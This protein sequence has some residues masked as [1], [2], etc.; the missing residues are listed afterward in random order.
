[1]ALTNRRERFWDQEARRRGVRTGALITQGYPRINNHVNALEAE[2]RRAGVAV[3]DEQR[4]D[5]SVR[6]F[7][8][9]IGGRSAG[10]QTS[11][12][13]KP[14]SPRWICLASNRPMQPLGRSRA[15]RTR[16]SQRGERLER[17][18]CSVRA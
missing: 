14:S 3:A 2:V 15:A 4:F 12:T 9:I 11:I 10:I 18:A 1:V 16:L 6:D 17:S 13:L 8:S 5:E 7:R